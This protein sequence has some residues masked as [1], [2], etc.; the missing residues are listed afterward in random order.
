[1]LKGPDRPIN[2]H[3]DRKRLLEA[4]GCVDEVLIFDSEDE[5]RNYR[6]EISPSCMVKG[7]EWTADEVRQRDH[8]PL[9]T[10]IKIF[11]QVVNYSTTDTL[12]K[13]KSINK[14]EKS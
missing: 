12:R 10:K 8:V 5:L 7:G 2:N 13:V 14:W 4:L 9:A 6:D 1:M 3:N 11:P